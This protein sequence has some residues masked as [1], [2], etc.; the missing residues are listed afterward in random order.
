MSLEVLNSFRLVGGTSLSLQ[1]GHRN[2]VDIDLFTDIDYNSV[3]FKEIDKK[4]TQQF[5]YV[6]IGFEGKEGFGKSYFVGQSKNESIKLDLFY[7]DKFI[8]N[9]VNFNNIRLAQIDEIIAMKLE[10]IGNNGRKKD[11]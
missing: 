8:R 7:T 1:I 10:V 6:D 3:D 5:P 9:S 11:F 4:L 2:S